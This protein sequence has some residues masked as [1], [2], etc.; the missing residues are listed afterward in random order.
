ML[1]SNTDD[2]RLARDQ[3]RLKELTPQRKECQRLSIARV[4]GTELPVVWDAQTAVTTR[5]FGKKENKKSG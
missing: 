5:R 1:R 4:G 3:R 2:E